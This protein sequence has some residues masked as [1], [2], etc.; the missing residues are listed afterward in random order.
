[1]RTTSQLNA[2]MNDGNT[3]QSSNQKT[4]KFRGA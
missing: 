1:M 2:L 4:L 3:K